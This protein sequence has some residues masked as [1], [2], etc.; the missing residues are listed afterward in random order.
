VLVTSQAAITE[1]I[2]KGQLE[3]QKDLTASLKPAKI[4]YLVKGIWLDLAALN[5]KSPQ[6]TFTIDVP[7]NDNVT[8]TG[9]LSVDPTISGKVIIRD[10]TLDYF[11]MEYKL[12]ETFGLTATTTL[13]ELNLEKEVELAEVEFPT[14]TIWVGVVPVLVTPT[15]TLTLGAS[16]DLKSELT[17]GITQNLTVTSGVVDSLGSWNPYFNLM[18]SFG[19]SGPSISNT[20]E[21][22]IYLKPQI[23][24]LFY[25]IISPYLSTELYGLV[26]ADPATTPWWKLYAGLSA[27]IGVDIKIWELTPAN[28]SENLFDLKILIAD[29]GGTGN[30]DPVASFT[31]Q[32]QNGTTATT[33]L[34]DASGCHDPDEPTSSLE[35]RW[36]WEGDGIWDEPYSTVK[37]ATHEFAAG[38][39]HIIL[40]VKDT[41]GLTDTASYTLQVETGNPTSTLTD[42]RDG[43]VYTIVQIG[44][45]WW[46]AQNLNY[47][48]RITAHYMQKDNG[49][50]EKYCYDDDESGCDIYGG[51]YQWGETMQ[52]DTVEVAQGICPPGW[53]VPTVA[54]WNDLIG[55]LGGD[56]ITGG[57]LK[58]YGTMYWDAPNTGASNVSGFTAIGAGNTIFNNGMSVLK[59][60]QTEF[61]SSYLDLPYFN[62]KTIELRYDSKEAIHAPE[63]RRTGISVRCI[64]D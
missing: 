16:L 55:Y 9:S 63:E 41:E 18:K 50:P 17:A 28:F 26:E 1:I 57:K 11:K 14:I 32:P 39:H 30:S 53:H 37:T 48:T 49:I 2:E 8:I 13:A 27:D 54:E 15:F 35:V 43:K 36:D 51:L 45:R 20:A 56:S 34:F 47:G 52:Y 44:S 19:H 40:E 29:A 46:M 5:R 23:N 59:N 3:F 33:F 38:S 24:M 10:Y 12:V 42:P 31:V 6:M 60:Q 62:T 7:L 58:L 22:K 25:E 61:W 64:K 4:R 21:A